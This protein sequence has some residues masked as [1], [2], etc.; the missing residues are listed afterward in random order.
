MI[1]Q[2]KELERAGRWAEIRQLAPGLLSSLQGVDL[3]QAHMALS[4]AHFHTATSAVDWQVALR[5]AHAC[6]QL[7]PAGDLLHTWALQKVSSLAVDMGRHQEAK[8]HALAY[9]KAAHAH[10]KLTVITPYVIRDLGHV[11]YQNRQF[12][13]AACYWRRALALFQ[14]IGNTDETTRTAITLAWAYVRSGKSGLAQAVLPTA[15]P[16][17]MEH[18]RLGAEAAILAA[19]GHWTEAFTA[20]TRA[21]QGARAAHDYADAAEVC[22]ILSKAFQRLGAGNQALDFLHTAAK[23]AA[24]QDRDAYALLTLSNRAGGGDFPRVHAA[25]PCGA[26]GLHLDACYTTGVA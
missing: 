25:A 5:H 2:V 22:L 23:F 13:A 3:A 18:L 1:D 26:G 15:V 14:T 4:T 17:H 16:A 11:A 8:R 10:P 20:G 19:D 21:L 9:L 7:A 6:L 12:K 24:R